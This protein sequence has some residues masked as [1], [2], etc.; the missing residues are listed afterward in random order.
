[1][2]F[3][4][5]VTPSCSYCRRGTSIGN[6]EVACVRRGITS[7]N[8]SCKRFIYD[9]LKREPEIPHYLAKNI[10]PEDVSAE[11]FTI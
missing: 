2:L 5:K 6:G 11:D 9:P 7:L 1:M 3:S 10:L 4:P 8:G